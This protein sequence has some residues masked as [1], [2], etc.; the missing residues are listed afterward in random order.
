VI[1]RDSRDRLALA[2]RRYAAGRITNDDLDAIDVDSG[3]RGAAA[4]KHRAW[5]LYD[6]LMEH[7]ATAKYLI[8]REG[9]RELARWVVF[10]HSEHEYLWPE[11]SFIDVL[12]IPLNLLTL[13][14]WARYRSR[15]YAEFREAGDFP[16][17][18]FLR[19]SEFEA[20]IRTPKFLSGGQHR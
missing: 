10:L 19:T 15:R 11:F 12:N 8:P 2:L 3:D 4:I 9:R 16:V 5:F 14:W 20:A 6:D 7:R 18:P 13:G 1:C 17:W